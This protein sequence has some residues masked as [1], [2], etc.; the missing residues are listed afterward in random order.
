MRAAAIL[1]A[2]TLAACG[3]PEPAAEGDAGSGQT[4]AGE[5][6]GTETRMTDSPG[7]ESRSRRSPSEELSLEYLEGTWCFARESGGGENPSDKCAA[8]KGREIGIASR[9][10]VLR[11]GEAV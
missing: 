8:I 4:A 7:S 1:L 2:L 5:S 3:G 11:M 9:R 10:E 6:S